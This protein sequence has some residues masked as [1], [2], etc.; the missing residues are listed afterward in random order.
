MT[1]NGNTLFY[2]ILQTIEKRTG[3]EQIKEDLLLNVKF[4]KIFS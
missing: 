3:T 1:I 4:L 2:K